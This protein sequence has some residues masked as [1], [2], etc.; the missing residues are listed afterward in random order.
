MSK[1][2]KII[3]LNSEVLESYGGLSLLDKFN[4]NEGNEYIS[5]LTDVTD[6]DDIYLISKVDSHQLHEYLMKNIDLYE[7]IKSSKRW[8]ECR[9][10][11]DRYEVLRRFKY[12]GSIPEE[13]LLDV[14][15]YSN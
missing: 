9:S 7:L 1:V 10:V 11:G 8:Y 13:C 4:D 14:G 12:F 15:F 2:T 3:P 6:T 5:L